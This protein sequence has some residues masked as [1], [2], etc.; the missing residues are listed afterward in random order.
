MNLA[1]TKSQLA[2][3]MAAENITVQ[4]QKTATASFDV[5]NR[6][7][8]LP[9]FEDGMSNDVYDLMVSHE[10][11]HAL[12]TPEDG[13]HESV[14]ENGPLYKGFLNIIEDARIERKIRAKFPGLASSYRNGYKELLDRNFFGLEGIDITEMAFIDRI[15]IFFKTGTLTGLQFEG[16]E[17]D[18]VKKIATAETFEEVKAIADA[19]FASE[20]EKAEEKAEEMEANGEFDEPEWDEDFDDDDA[21]GMFMDDDG[22]EAE[23]EFDASASATDGEGEETEEENAE[24]KSSGTASDIDQGET[25]EA[26]SESIQ[27][28]AANETTAKEAAVEDL[29]GGDTERELHKN[30]RGLSAENA[31]DI[32]YKSLP[33]SVKGW[34]NF[35]VGYKD[36]ITEFKNNENH[37]Y[38]HQL[39]EVKAKTEEFRKSN[40]SVISL[41]AKEFEMRKKADEHKRTSVAKSGEL[42][43]NKIF[44]Y[45]FN[46]DLFLRNAVVR[47]GKNHGFVMYIDW[48]G[49]MVNQ[50]AGTIDQLLNLVM[51]CRK[52]RIPFEVFSFTDQWMMN[53]EEYPVQAQDYSDG[54]MVPQR[55][56]LVQLFSTQMSVS[57]FNTQVENMMMV[58]QSLANGRYYNI[59]LP[60]NMSLGTTPLNSALT[61]STDV[62]NA[63]KKKYRVQICNFVVLTDGDSHNSAEIKKDEFSG[64]RGVGHCYDGGYRTDVYVTDSVTKRNYKVTRNMTSIL[65][66]AIKARTG[67]NTIGIYLVEN[68]P[69]DIRSVLAGYGLYNVDVKEFR[70]NR[71]AA[72]TSAG[73]DTY[74]IMPGGDLALGDD[75]LTVDAGASKARIKSA[76]LK[77]TKGKTESRVF[78]KQLMEI[79]A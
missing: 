27:S 72:V 63:F 40:K 44:G 59:R 56:R 37:V 21:D 53:R 12:W 8:T 55:F 35:I 70:A 26:E 45:K 42:D 30:V 75:G 73:Y 65:L 47:E 36:V 52:V 2:K 23:E 46:E 67:C 71:F 66:Q 16:E 31:R 19:L 6:V 7:L 49:S 17:L 3:L 4:H 58:R 14:C 11:G 22:E 1:N 43:M 41:M 10:V 24:D 50:M 38:P 78:V 62:I 61:I 25:K 77:H 29:M 69:R 13:W 48:S 64:E 39:A 76:F 51:F 57:D 32:E 15:N 74:F 68:K 20:K 5:K 9:V 54:D 34:E 60:E 28:G 79:A 33:A 18:W